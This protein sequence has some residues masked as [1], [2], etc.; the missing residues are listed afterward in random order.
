M[1]VTNTSGDSPNPPKLSMFD[2]I[3]SVAMNLNHS[4]PLQQSKSRPNSNTKSKSPHNN[5]TNSMIFNHISM[6]N[7]G[8]SNNKGNNNGNQIV[9][10]SSDT[11][12][13]YYNEYEKKAFVDE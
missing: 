2:L 4:L 3:P 12:E 7:N 1:D 10:Q 8:N 5:S 11:L 9:R 13:R 6:N